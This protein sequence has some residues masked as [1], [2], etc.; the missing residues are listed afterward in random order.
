MLDLAIQKA[1][2]EIAGQVEIDPHCRAILTKN[3]PNVKRMKDIKHVRGNEFGKIDLV[4]G[5]I[6]CQPFSLSGEQRG[7]EDDRH[8]WPEAARIIARIRPTWVLIENVANFLPMVLDLVQTDLE[9][10]GYEVWAAVLPACAVEA[11]HIRERAIIVA[12]A[13][14]RQRNRRT[15]L[16]GGWDTIPESQCGANSD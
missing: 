6:P 1:G 15:G 7:T 16:S 9:S 13:N 10:Q 2:F 12:H 11:P 14:R 8:L 3:Y 4:A 5:G